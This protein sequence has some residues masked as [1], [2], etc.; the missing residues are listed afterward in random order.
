MDNIKE[1]DDIFASV[2]D[3]ANKIKRNTNIAIIEIGLLGSLAT[4]LSGAG[5]LA[6]FGLPV[7]DKI[8]GLEEGSIV[9]NFVKRVS[10]N[11]L[12][13]IHDFKK[14]NLAKMYKSD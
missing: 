9:E 7:V 4:G 12:V 14:K 3:E 1:A 13:T 5:M 8:L 10:P 6:S 11:H 2:Y